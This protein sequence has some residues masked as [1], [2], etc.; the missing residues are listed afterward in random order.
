MPGARTAGPGRHQRRTWTPTSRPAPGR[1]R[2]RPSTSPRFPVPAIWSITGWIQHRT[3]STS[4][5]RAVFFQATRRRPGCQHEP[6]KTGEEHQSGRVSVGEV[7]LDDQ[8]GEHDGDGHGDPHSRPH[9]RAQP[10]QGEQR[11]DQGALLPS[12]DQPGQAERGHEQ[13]RAGHH[14]HDDRRPKHPP[15]SQPHHGHARRVD[16]RRTDR[17]AEVGRD[18]GERG[19]HVELEGPEIV[20]RHA[21]DRRARRPCPDKRM[22]GRQHVGRA[23]GE[24]RRVAD[25]DPVRDGGADDGDDERSQRDGQSQPLERRRRTDSVARRLDHCSVGGPPARR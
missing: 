18:L 2:A 19:E 14:R 7:G 13:R 10:Q 12:V 25:R 23:N 9:R 20:H 24:V 8:A 17:R 6:D 1:P 16:Q 3:P 15:N 22:M 5:Q 11:Q 21:D 4:D